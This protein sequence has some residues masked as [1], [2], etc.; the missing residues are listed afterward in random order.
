MSDGKGIGRLARTARRSAWQEEADQ[1]FKVGAKAQ[2]S[3]AGRASRFAQ[4]LELL[5][6]EDRKI[7]L[8]ALDEITRPMDAREIEKALMITDLSMNDRK[9]VVAA[10]KPYRLVLVSVR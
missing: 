3:G 6:L 2:G 8:S 9:R 1:I 10:L 7:I 5:P 4:A